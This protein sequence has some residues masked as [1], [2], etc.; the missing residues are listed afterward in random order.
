[1][2]R[3]VILRF[4]QDQ[5]GEASV[6]PWRQTLRFAQGDKRNHR[7]TV[8]ADDADEHIHPAMIRGLGS[9]FKSSSALSGPYAPGIA[10][11]AV[12]GYFANRI[13]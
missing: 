9:A 10:S 6:G 5:R 8:G 7:K 1:V 13:F 3:P 2:D 4:A 11:L 12:V